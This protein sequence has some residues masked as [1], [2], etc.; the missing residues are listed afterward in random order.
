[1]NPSIRIYGG[2]HNDPGSRQQFLKELTKRRTAPHFVAVEWEKSVFERFAAWRLRIAEGISS[3]WDFLTCKDCHELS[4]AFAWEGDAH[5]ERFP[6]TEI[7]WLESG[8]Q[9]ADLERRSRGAPKKFL[10]ERVDCLLEQLRN[11]CRPTFREV[12]ANIVPPEP[13]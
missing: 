4:R 1:M 13:R 8:F 5:T 10:A 12:M 11:P 7:L 9:E 3:H 6:D 2:I